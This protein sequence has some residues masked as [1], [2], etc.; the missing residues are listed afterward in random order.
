MELNDCVYKK[1]TD[2]VER[3]MFHD[4]PRENIAQLFSFFPVR[5]HDW[6]NIPD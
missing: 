2:P 1:K 4:M 3:G 6:Y 5:M